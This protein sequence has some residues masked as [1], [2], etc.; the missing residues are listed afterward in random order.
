MTS[1]YGTNTTRILITVSAFYSIQHNQSATL[2]IALDKGRAL[3][4]TQISPSD[5]ANDKNSPWTLS[6]G[7]LMLQHVSEEKPIASATLYPC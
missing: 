1:D 7:L 4:A 2:Y 6:G 5:A 3:Y